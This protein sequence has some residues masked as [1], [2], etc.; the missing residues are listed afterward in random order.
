MTMIVVNVHEAKA[1]LSEYLDLAARGER[2]LICN[3]N[4]PVA[5]LRAV[6]AA[7][8]A[9]RKVGGGKG[10]RSV[11]AAFC[12]PLPDDVVAPCFEGTED[13]PRAKAA[14]APAGYDARPRP[15]R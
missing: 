4:R 11:P 13:V 8:A 1:K 7:A 12:E 15:G 3:R 5:E 10:R 6:P 14:E 9:P 2:V